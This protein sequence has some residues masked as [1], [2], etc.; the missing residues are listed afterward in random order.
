MRPNDPAFFSPQ[1]RLREIARLLATGLRRLSVAP[2][3]PI[4]HPNPGPEKPPE[5]LPELP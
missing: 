1:E 4:Y 5:K 3:A 2:A